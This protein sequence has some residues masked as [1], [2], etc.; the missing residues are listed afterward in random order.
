MSCSTERHL[1]EETAEEYSLEQ[2]SDR[3]LKDVEAHL[4]ICESCRQTVA[5]SDAYVR[6]MRNAASDLR[7]EEQKPKKSVAG[8]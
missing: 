5:A 8:K 2:L 3:N 6:A 7:R 1:D 4:L